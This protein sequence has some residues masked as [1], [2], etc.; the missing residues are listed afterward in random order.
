[1]LGRWLGIFDHGRGSG[2]RLRSVSEAAAGVFVC[3]YTVARATTFRPALVTIAAG[4]VTAAVPSFVIWTMSG[5]EN[6]LLTLAAAAMAAIM[7]RVAGLTNARIARY[8]H[9][10]NWLPLRDYV[11]GETR[12]TFIKS[13]FPWSDL[14]GI[15][16]D[17]RMAAD[18][19]IIGSTFGTTDWVRRDTLTDPA[20][21]QHLQ[22][23][24]TTVVYPADIAVRNSPRASCGDR[25][26]ASGS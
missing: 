8:W 24:F 15:P 4:A 26:T 20:M 14:T 19:V 22:A 9:D 16:S 25:L 17:P 10:E 5:L 7:V 3:F 11:F 21:L 1:V 6:G 23:H 12:P 13:H 18:Y 2:T